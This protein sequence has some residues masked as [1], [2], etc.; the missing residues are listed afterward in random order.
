ME[1]DQATD[2]FELFTLWLDEATITE[3][4]D[5]NAMALATATATGVPSV[6]IVLLKAIDR[7]GCV[8]YTNLDSRKGHELASNPHAALC[9]HWKSLRRQIRIDGT[10]A[11]V[12]A[13]EAD[14]YFRSRPRDSR[15]GAWASDQSRPLDARATLLER[16]AAAEARFPGEDV[17]CPPHWSGFRL[18]PQRFEFWCDRPFRLHDRLVFSAGSD[19]RWL[20]TWLYP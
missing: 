3:P 7:Q 11:P 20:R 9:F 18:V 2:P 14:A 5:A 1:M 16:I 13:A 19:Q 12:A 8:F 10:V 15:I 17:P 6:R 4:N